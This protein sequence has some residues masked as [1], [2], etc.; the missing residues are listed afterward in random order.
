M[1]L[2][3]IAEKEV[4]LVLHVLWCAGMAKNE[5]HV[6]LSETPV[7]LDNR[8]D[9]CTPCAN[10]YLRQIREGERTGL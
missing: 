7:T 10:D 6:Y 8:K 3:R 2:E 5:P 4:K 1:S 9:Y